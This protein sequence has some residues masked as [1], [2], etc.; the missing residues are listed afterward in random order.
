MVIQALWSAVDALRPWLHGLWQASWQGALWAA[1]AWA[2][3][4]ALPRLP[5]AV[6][7]G[8]WWLVSLKFLVSLVGLT[9]VPLPLL[10]APALAPAPPVALHA[11]PPPGVGGEAP[12]LKGGVP[13][14][15]SPNAP[16]TTLLVVQGVLALLLAA[17]ALGAAW[18]VRGHLQSHAAVRRLRRNARPLHHPELEAAVRTLA[19]EAGLRRVPAL[20]V[21]DEVA[22][23]LAVGLLRPLVILPERAVRRLPV[24]ALRMALA[25]E[26]AHVRRGDLWLGWVPALAEA[27]LFFHPLARLAVREYALAREESC[28]AEALRLTGAEPGDYGQLLL[29][30]GVA[31]AHG[32][33]AAQGASSHLHA[34]HRRLNMLEFV[35]VSRPRTLL[36]GALALLGLVALVPF[37]V[38]AREPVAPAQPAASVTPVA[39]VSSARP[40]EPVKLAQAAPPAKPAPAAPATP[41]APPTS[42]TK[43]TPPTPPP[44]PAPSARPPAPPAPPEHA[45]HGHIHLH[46]DDDGDAYIFATNNGQMMMSGSSRD[47]ERVKLLREGGKDLLWVRRDGTE[48]VIRDPETL[49]QVRASFEMPRELGEQQAALGQKQAALGE[50]Q[51]AI[52]QKQAEIGHQQAQ[53]GVK[54]AELAREQADLA[55]LHARMA[56]ARDEAEQERLEKELEPKE[57]ALDKK[58]DAL[59]AQMEALS[60]KMEALSEQME[61]L[62]EKQ[63]DLG[64]EQQELGAK[65]RRVVRDAERKLSSLVDEA[66]RKGIAQ[67]VKS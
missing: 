45:I 41:P 9:P 15:E 38:V 34:L 46:D 4:R 33:A 44:P 52:G 13:M 56:A 48:Y 31:R 3:T 30:F 58:R 60:E 54:Q 22:S 10:P 40:A 5:S 49:Q 29:T 2:V 65:M 18:Q 16:V 61:P 42:A 32:P 55:V 47:L 8:L 21:S 14:V 6:R 57:E 19:A 12:L 37:Q 51:A 28:D 50:Q 24:E 67:P 59:S 27:V 20:S 26:L 1:L 35:D 7:A 11:L 53:L 23:P 63:E 64:D 66:V 25:H 43:P 17:W 36:Q 39:P 62:S